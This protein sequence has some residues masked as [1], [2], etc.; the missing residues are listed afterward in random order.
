MN[1]PTMWRTFYDREQKREWQVRH[2]ELY[3]RRML[4]R[5][6]SDWQWHSTMPVRIRQQLNDLFECPTEPV[7]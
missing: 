4:P 5:G 2:G 3:C 7:G 6:W 1:K